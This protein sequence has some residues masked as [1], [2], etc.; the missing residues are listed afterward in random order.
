MHFRFLAA[1]VLLAAA[2]TLTAQS[3]VSFE[4]NRESYNI[5]NAFATVQ[6]DF[7]GD[8]KPDI[9]AGGGTSAAPDTVMLQLGKGDGTFQ[10]PQEVGPV[11]NTILDLAAADMNQDGK[12]DVV[13]LDITG[14]FAVFYGNGDGTFQAPLE[15]ATSASPRSLTTG[16]FF[17][18]G[19]LDVA[20]GDVNGAVEL[21][22]NG[23]G[24]AFVLAGTIPV[25]SGVNPDVL[26]VR[27]GNVDG[28]GIEDLGVLTYGAAYVLWGDGQG[29]FTPRQLSTYVAPSGLNV[30]NV[31]Q[32]GRS[33]IL[34]SYI[35]NPTPI[36]NPD[37]GPQYNPCAGFDVFY[38]QGGKKI[39]KQT[40]VT[41]PGV[42]PVETPWAVDV[43]GDGIADLV[44]SSRGG[45]AASGLYVWLGSWT[46]KFAQT[47]RAFVA[48]SGGAAGLVPGDWNRDGMTDFAVELP[49]DAQVEIY[50]NGGNR[51]A[52]ASSSIPYTVTVCQ[53]VDNTYATSPVTVDATASGGS[54]EITALQEYI[55]GQEVDAV[56]GA[57]FDRRFSIAPGT[58][59]LV[60]KA[61]DSSGMS[62]RSDRIITVFSGTAGA[63]C[64]A[65]PESANICL[66]PGN[67]S[68]SSVHILA[69]GSTATI[70]TAA[71]LYIDGDL[72]VNNQ[73]CNASGNC[74][75]GTSY[76]DTMQ[77]LAS[78]SHSLVFKLWDANGNVRTAQKSLTVQ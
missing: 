70:P 1:T 3:N 28:T 37:K 18:D 43:N 31:A 55:D 68:G 58:H 39:V 9:V 65:A 45:G 12:L 14:D 76:V 66:P 10:A 21:F 46:G 42:Y 11:H 62:F 20:V 61:W 72:V 4:L 71:Q 26:Q 23:G 13:A 74:G 54:N 17:G 38:G 27:A 51:A 41:D 30:T 19:Y 32:D 64:P 29:D 57:S 52:C 33:D 35:C 69:N 44:G 59:S 24:K 47:P 75:G 16:N 15:V 2:A 22:R 67:T 5:Y 63:A 34:V 7:N 40:V 25:G 77:A 6:G 49:G 8:G 78:G 48:T 73:G 60:T 36:N 53:P 50:T 56:D